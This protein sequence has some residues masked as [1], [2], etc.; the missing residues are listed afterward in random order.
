MRG[1]IRAELRIPAAAHQQCVCR[2][3]ALLQRGDLRGGVG[4]GRLG[5]S[6]RGRR[7]LGPPLRLR[8]LPLRLLRLLPHDSS[9]DF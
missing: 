3:E 9:A 4:G 8:R 6:A 2:C 1:D 5:R 7:L